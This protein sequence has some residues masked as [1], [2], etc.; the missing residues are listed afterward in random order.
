MRHALEY[1]GSLGHLLGMLLFV[2]GH[3]WFGVMTTL[4]ERHHDSPGARFLAQYLPQM[5]NVFG[6]GVLLLFASGLLRL[7]VWNEPGL[8]F[9]P[10]PYGW[11]L[12]SK[13]LLY[14]LIVLNG[15]WIERRYL[16]QVLR[17]EATAD[18]TTTAL[19]LTPAWTQ[20]KVRARLNLLLVLV[21]IALGEA[22]R[23]ARE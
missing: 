18:G 2:G 13:L 20:L 9:L 6:T 22:L 12:F 23:Y 16:P 10:D 11:I 3:L 17:A 15:A 1:V 19:H 7:F 5:A 21:A 14:M 8:L 4:A